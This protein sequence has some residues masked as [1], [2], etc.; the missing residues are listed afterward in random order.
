MRSLAIP[1]LTLTDVIEFLISNFPQ[2]NLE[3]GSVNDG[4]SHQ[5][6]GLRGSK[7]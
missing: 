4:D 7:S 5:R 1:Y 2:S 6:A 3:G